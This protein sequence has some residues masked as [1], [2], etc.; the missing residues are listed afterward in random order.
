MPARRNC[1]FLP[2][3]V[4]HFPCFFSKPIYST[5]RQYVNNYVVLA[6]YKQRRNLIH[7]IILSWCAFKKVVYCRQIQICQIPL[8]IK[9]KFIRKIIIEGFYIRD[10]KNISISQPLSTTS[11]TRLPRHLWGSKDLI[12]SKWNSANPL[13]TNFLTT[14]TFK[15]EFDA[16]T[17]TLSLEHGKH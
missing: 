8:K 5:S 14:T 13:T 2:K 10:V 7:L 12:H 17:V 16:V 1:R 6:H 4:V 15:H 3:P 9:L 11:T